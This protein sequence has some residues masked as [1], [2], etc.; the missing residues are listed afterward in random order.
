MTLVLDEGSL[1]AVVCSVAG[2]EDLI[3]LMVGQVLMKLHGHCSFQK[4][5][6]E[7]KVGN[8]PVVAE[9]NRV[10]SRLF[11]DSRLVTDVILKLEGTVPD[12]REVLGMGSREQMET[13]GKWCLN[14]RLREHCSV[15]H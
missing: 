15:P 11:E 12:C 1:C 9:V 5:T 7:R 4:L 10:Q 14:C 13:I 2:L 8:R 3:E 6:V